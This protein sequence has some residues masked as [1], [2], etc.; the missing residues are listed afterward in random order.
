MGHMRKRGNRWYAIVNLPRDVSG[1]RRQKWH[2]G[3]RAK[4]NADAALTE[5][6]TSLGRERSGAARLARIEA[7]RRV[8]D[9]RR[10]D[11]KRILARLN[12]EI[13]DV[14][15]KIQT[16]SEAAQAVAFTHD[17][18]AQAIEAVVG[19]A[20]MKASARSDD[21]L[22]RLVRMLDV[23][24]DLQEREDGRTIHVTGNISVHELSASVRA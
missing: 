2:S 3:F 11:A 12:S 10:D 15:S 6:L 13:E 17:D 8:L 1:K 18:L 16:Y 14:R 4:R 24:I 19:D 9:V 7:R 21:D 5:I 23:R 20:T 22:R